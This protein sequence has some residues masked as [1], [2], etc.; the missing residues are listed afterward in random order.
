[1]GAK[2]ASYAPHFT[3]PITPEESV[4][5]ITAVLE[6]K[7]VERGDAGTFV[8]HFGNQQWL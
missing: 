3:G 8:S 1:M 2:F 5:Y 4:K 6:T 7:A